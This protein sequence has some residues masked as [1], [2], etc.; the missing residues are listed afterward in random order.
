[1]TLAIRVFRGA[2]FGALLTLLLHPISRPYFA[3]LLTGPSANHI[4]ALLESDQ[5]LKP[6]STVREAAEWTLQAAGKMASSQPLTKKELSSLLG[7]VREA[8]RMDRANAY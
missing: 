4:R 1:M 6:P 2:A 8:K 7:L 3:G 5:T